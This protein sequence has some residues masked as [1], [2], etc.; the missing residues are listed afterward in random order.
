MMIN[1]TF[2]KAQQSYLNDISNNLNNKVDKSESVENIKTPISKVD[3]IKAEIANGDYK[4]DLDLTAS[5]M[6]NQLLG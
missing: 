6:A 1:N 4:I 3:K 5:K 2:V